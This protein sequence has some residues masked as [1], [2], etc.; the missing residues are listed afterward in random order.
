MGQQACCGLEA[1]ARERARRLF[2]AGRYAGV[3]AY[4][5]TGAGA[6]VWSFDLPAVI[7]KAQAERLDEEV[8]KRRRKPVS[9]RD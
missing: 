3:D 8:N 4:N 1:A 5:V 6:L 9:S 2:D 7:I